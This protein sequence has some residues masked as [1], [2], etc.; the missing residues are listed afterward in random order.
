MGEERDQKKV[1]NFTMPR[2]KKLYNP[3]KIVALPSDRR[4]RFLDS[5]LDE[6]HILKKKNHLGKFV[7]GAPEGK[8]TTRNVTQK[9]CLQPRGGGVAGLRKSMPGPYG[10]E[11]NKSGG[12]GGV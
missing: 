2:G 3:E 11:K 5:T 1:K 10:E 4:G 6:K 7:K 8:K 12:G 9:K